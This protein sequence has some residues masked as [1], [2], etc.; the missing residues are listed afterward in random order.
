MERKDVI[1]PQ[2][3]DVITDPNRRYDRQF[4]SSGLRVLLGAAVVVSGI[5]AALPPPAAAQTVELRWKLEPGADHVYRMA[6]RG[7]SEL[8]QGMGTS[9]MNM[10]NTQRWNVLE[11]DGD[12]AATVRI[13]T[14]RV[15]MSV[16]GGPMG[17]MSVDSA[18]PENAGSP[19]EAMKAI[20]GT[21]YTVVLDPRGAL[22]EMSG[23]EELREALRAQTPDPS[24][25]AMLDQFL[26]DDAMRSQWA[27]GAF[28]LPAEA[29]GVGS[30]WEGAY[31]SPALPFGSMTVANAYRVES[32]DGDIVVIGISG[33]MSV[34]DDAPASF[35]IP[36]KLGDTTMVGTGRFDAARGLLLGTDSTMTLQMSMEMGGQETVLDT[37]M[38]VTIELIEGQ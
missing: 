8:P 22:V 28:A 21:S 2:E 23:L 19:L 16:G 5:G 1:L 26:S 18:D 29:L 30:T 10:E 6:M 35:P 24:A 34:A 17:T 12:G 9:T 38:T 7:E 31:T 20:A 11:V 4:P 32:I 36:M 27:Q 33:T 37:A 15:R 3:V 25:Q 13:T 14:E